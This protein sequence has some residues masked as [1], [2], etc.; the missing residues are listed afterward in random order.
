VVFDVCELEASVVN[1]LCNL[2]T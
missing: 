2:H 1:C